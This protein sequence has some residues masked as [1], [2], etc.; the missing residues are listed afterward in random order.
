MNT[1]VMVSAAIIGIALI[2]ITIREV[3]T[4]DKLRGKDEG[5]PESSGDA[6]TSFLLASILDG[7]SSHDSTLQADTTTSHH[8][9]CESG[10]HDSGGS[11]CESHSGFDAGGGHH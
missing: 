8:G 7:S 2:L 3:Q 10:G 4:R 11:G 1:F 9:T 6:D 5:L